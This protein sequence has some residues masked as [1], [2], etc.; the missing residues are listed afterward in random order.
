M[1]KSGMEFHLHTVGVKIFVSIKSIGFHK[2]NQSAAHRMLISK[3]F[4]AESGKSPS[5]K[6]SAIELPDWKKSKLSV[7]TNVCIRNTT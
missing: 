2:N 5:A 4:G 6:S 7:E 1:K 3:L